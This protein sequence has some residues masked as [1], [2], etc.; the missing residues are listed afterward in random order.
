MPTTNT[1]QTPKNKRLSEN[2][3]N[4]LLRLAAKR[5]EETTDAAEL[6]VAYKVA[7]KAITDATAKT[8]PPK[9][10]AVL[11][12]YGCVENDSCIYFTGSNGAYG[13]FFFRSADKGPQRPRLRNCNNRNPFLLDDEGSEAVTRYQELLETHKASLKQRQ[14]D[15]SALIATAASFNELAAIWPAAEELRESI[16]GAGT[17]LLVMNADVISRIK[18]DPAALV[19]A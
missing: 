15:F 18:A 16:V 14:N 1:A 3:R 19:S 11:A 4:A 10:M 5:I 8:Y 2:N 12:K 6:D 9:D 7:A 13:Q 17:S